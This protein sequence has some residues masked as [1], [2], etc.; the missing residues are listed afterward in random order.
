MG[1]DPARQ[2]DLTATM[3]AS[4]GIYQ[5]IATATARMLAAAR[6]ADWDALVSA[7]S[8]CASHIE[9]ARAATGDPLDAEGRRLKAQ[10][11]RRMLADDA[12]IRACVQPWMK[13]LEEMLSLSA[14]RA[15]AGDSYRHGAG[16]T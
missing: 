3:N 16:D 5:D 15:R 11:I 1:G 7:E 13:Q 2:Q 9:R 4:I 8:A 10:L 14:R 12:E 6:R